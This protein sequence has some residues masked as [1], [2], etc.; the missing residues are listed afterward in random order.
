MIEM[1]IWTIHVTVLIGHNDH[2]ALEGNEAHLAYDWKQ[3]FQFYVVG[4]LQR[5]L[6]SIFSI[7]LEADG[8][9]WLLRLFACVSLSHDRYHSLLNI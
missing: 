8:A 3:S 6:H 7:F 9:L 5:L 4:L 1:T 2:H